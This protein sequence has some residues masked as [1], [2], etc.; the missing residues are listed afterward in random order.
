[1]DERIKV[2]EISDLS[3]NTID[4]NKV[5]SRISAYLDAGRAYTFHFSRENLEDVHMCLGDDMFFEYLTVL[6]TVTD[7]EGVNYIKAFL[8]TFDA[9]TK[10]EQIS[11]INRPA[12]ELVSKLEAVIFKYESEFG[13]RPEFL[14]MSRKSFNQLEHES[15]SNY[16]KLCNNKGQEESPKFRDIPIA[17]CP[18][19]RTTYIQLIPT[20]KCNSFSHRPYIIHKGNLKPY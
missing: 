20:N 13:E 2:K 1:M 10:K 7:K 3:H 5:E 17:L 6:E 14:I 19:K 12:D 11:I 15:Y 9:P 18:N 8:D 16:G 4:I